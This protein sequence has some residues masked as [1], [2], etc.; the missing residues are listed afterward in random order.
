MGHHIAQ[1]GLRFSIFKDD[2]E[3]KIILP[4]PPEC[5]DDR[6]LPPQ[7]VHTGLG[8]EPEDSGTVAKNSIN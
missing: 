1:A 7:M 6:L 2:L 8:T 4:L 5:W 3:H